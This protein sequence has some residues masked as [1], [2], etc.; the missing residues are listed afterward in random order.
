MP[1]TRCPSASRRSARL[2]PMNPATPVT[3]MVCRF[4]IPRDRGLE[5]VLRAS[6]VV[7]EHLHCLAREFGEVFAKQL[8]LLQQVRRGGDDVTAAL[9]RLVGVP[10]LAR[11]GPQHPKP[12][13][14]TADVH[15]FPHDGHGIAASVGDAP[16]KY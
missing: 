13:P 15:D 16:G 14:I 9:V 7:E 4:A 3:T 12:L 5:P 10:H 8:E 2:L 11:A 1:M 6:R